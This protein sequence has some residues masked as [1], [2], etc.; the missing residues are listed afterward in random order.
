MVILRRKD[1]YNIRFRESTFLIFLQN[2]FI[3]F[4][5]LSIIGYDVEIIFRAKN[6]DIAP[7]TD[8]YFDKFKKS[9]RD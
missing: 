4:Y 2:H 1:G 3:L 5:L 7:D 6:F 8:R 9:G